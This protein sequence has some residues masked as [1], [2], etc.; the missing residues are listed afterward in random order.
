MWV[1]RDRA[2]LLAEAFRAHAREVEQLALQLPG[3]Q[4]MRS[5]ALACAGALALIGEQLAAG[6]GP[7]RVRGEQLREVGANT[8][9]GLRRMVA[10]RGPQ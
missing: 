2:N 3:D 6:Q 8:R 9:R 4:D 10:N 7:V 1:S 5:Q